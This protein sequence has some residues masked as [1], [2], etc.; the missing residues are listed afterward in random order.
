MKTVEFTRMEQGTKEEY[1]FLDHL[2]DEFKLG[3]VDRL[4]SALQQLENSLSGYKISRLDHVLQAATRAHRAGESEQMVVAA[5]LHDLGDD[6]APYSHS[7]MAAAILRP[8][9]SEEIYW[10]VKHHGI[11]QMYYYAHHSGGDRNVRDQFKG[12]KYYDTA[13]RFCHEYDQNCF[14]PEYQ[15]EPLEFFRPMLERVTAKPLAFDVEHQ[16]RY[17]DSK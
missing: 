16:A 5:L 15:S 8:F 7:E 6:L 3:L 10:T 11:F 17:G 4:M 1:A 12:H 14:D 2:E 13:E 9:V